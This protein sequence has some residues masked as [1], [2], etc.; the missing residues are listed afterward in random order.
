V[1]ADEAY[2]YP[3]DLL[4]LLV[5]AIA[6]LVRSKESVIEFFRGAGVPRQLLGPWLARVK[7]ERDSIRKTD[8]TRNVLCAVNELGDNGLGLRREIIKRIVEWEDFSSCYPDKQLAAQ[9][10]VANIR[11]VVNIK[12]SFT[13]MNLARERERAA[14]QQA[15]QADILRKQREQEERESIKRDLYALFGSANAHKRGKAVEAVLNRFFEHSG[16]LV[17]EAFSLTGTGGQ[18][19]VEQIDGAI[20]FQGEIYLVE[21]GNGGTGRSVP[22]R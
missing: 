17:K 21:M 7:K 20:Q 8:I 6:C 4:N 9:G 12:D 15:Y 18:G 1:I 5:D 2:H 19:I 22:L 3:P 16:L 11:R 13:Q 14:Q 10:L